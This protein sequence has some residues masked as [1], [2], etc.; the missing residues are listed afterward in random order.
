MILIPYCFIVE[1]L[2]LS[3]QEIPPF[4]TRFHPS[5]HESVCRSEHHPG[6]IAGVYEHSLTFCINWDLSVL[7]MLFTVMARRLRTIGDLPRIMSIID[8]FITEST[9]IQQ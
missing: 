4:L 5:E 6:A 9:E 1:F 3:G 7:N 2:T 8:R